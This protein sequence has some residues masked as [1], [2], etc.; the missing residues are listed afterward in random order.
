S[1]RT[2][3]G[4]AQSR[5]N[6]NAR[7]F[8]PLAAPLVAHVTGS[9]GNPVSSVPLTLE[10][11]GWLFSPDAGLTAA[12]GTLSVTATAGWK[13]LSNTIRFR[14]P[15][16]TLATFHV[17][18]HDPDA[19]DVFPVFNEARQAGDAGLPSLSSLVQLTNPAGV[20]WDWSKAEL[21]VADLCR[22]VKVDQ[23]G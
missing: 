9:Y 7:W 6:Q 3:T 5:Y 20:T 13:Y 22:V 14:G 12:D 18:L 10:G 8:T 1:A 17:T 19:G 21:Y 4:Y 15:N 23:Y 2:G 16:S 11:N